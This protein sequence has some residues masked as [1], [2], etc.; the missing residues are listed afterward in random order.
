MTK[1]S[2]VGWHSS[3]KKPTRDALIRR[4][5]AY[6]SKIEGEFHVDVI[7]GYRQIKQRPTV[8]IGLWTTIQKWLGSEK[9]DFLIA[10]LPHF[11]VI[12][13][14]TDQCN[15]TLAADLR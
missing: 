13:K 2:E 4:F 12:M 15:L 7:T 8:M 5:Q 3:I 14:C 1:L 11:R 9:N 6:E 10:T